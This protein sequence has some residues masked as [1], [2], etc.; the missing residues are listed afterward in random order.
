M[1]V[2]ITLTDQSWAAGSLTAMLRAVGQ[3]ADDAGIDTI[4]VPDHL[5][6]AAP[7]AQ[8]DA[9]LEAFST[10]TYLASVTRTVRLGTM[11]SPVTYRSPA[12]LVKTVTTL[13]VLS[14]GR[15]W[16]GIGTGYHQQEADAM[17]LYL[18]APA[19]R[20]GRLE[21]TLRIARQMWADDGTPFEGRY[22]RLGHPVNHPR[23]VRQPHPPI[24]IGG[25]G[26]HRTLPLVA[27]Y[28]DACN[29]FDIPDGG[30]TLRHKLEVLADHCRKA[31]RDPGEVEKTISTRWDPG[32]TAQQL[33]D[34]LGSLSDLGLTHAVLL[35]VGPWY[36]SSIEALAAHL[37]AIGKF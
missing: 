17:G 9:M 8:G 1:K 24:L 26:E 23:P 2:S 21:E 34:H 3:A 35:R 37:D 16:L 33:T 13:D 11:V 7:G 32:W 12:L 20:Y 4:W 14:A 25:M 36:A 19:E 27:R 30:A 6:Q 5:I 18:P 29:L 10:L 31:N 22:Y 15:A 28:A